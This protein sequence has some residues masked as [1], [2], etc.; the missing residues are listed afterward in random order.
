MSLSKRLTKHMAS[1]T[2]QGAKPIFDLVVK[3]LSENLQSNQKEMRKETNY[4]KFAWSQ[5]MADKLGAQR[6]LD[7]LIKLFTIEEQKDV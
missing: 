2:I 4:E 7:E 5:Y 6:E 3:V 1:D